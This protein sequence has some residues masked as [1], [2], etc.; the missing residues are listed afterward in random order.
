VGVGHSFGAFTAALVPS[1]V[2]VDLLVLVSGMIA[3]PGSTAATP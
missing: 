2:P 1:R 3:L